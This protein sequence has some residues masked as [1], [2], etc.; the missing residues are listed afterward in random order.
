[1]YLSRKGY[2]E[3]I[4]SYMWKTFV[5]VIV[6][7]RRIWKTVIMKQIIEILPKNEVVY[8]NKEDKNFDFL[9]DEN[10]LN[11]FLENKISEWVKYIFVDEIQ[12]IKNWENCINSIFSK[13]KI[14]D[15]IISGSNGERDICVV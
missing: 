2:L 11:E 1:M 10:S 6:G 13:N 12:M 8:I 5:K 3:K 14:I 9:Y 15:I 7:Q 4:R